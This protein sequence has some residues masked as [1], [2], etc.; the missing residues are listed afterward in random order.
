MTIDEK[1]HEI[2]G[3]LNKVRKAG[4]GHSARCPAHNDKN[5]SLCL[6]I[7][8][9]HTRILLKCH[10]GCDTEAVMQQIG[11][12]LSYLFRDQ[13]E[14][15]KPIPSKRV[16]EYTYRSSEGT[17][18][19]RKIRYKPKSFSWEYLDGSE[20]KTGKGDFPEVP[21]RLGSF[22]D[23]PMVIIAE[24]EKDVDRLIKEGFPATCSSGSAGYWPNEIIKYFRDKTVTITYDNDKA[25]E[26]HKELVARK[27]FGIAKEIFIVPDLGVD[28]KG[29]VSDYFEL[30]NTADDFADLIQRAEAWSANG[31]PAEPITD[32]FPGILVTKTGNEWLRESKSRPMPRMLFGEFW[33]EGELCIL[34]A[35]TGLGKSTLAV[36]IAEY[37][38]RGRP[39]HPLK[40]EAVSQN[41]L[42]LD[43]EL[44]DKQFESR[45]SKDNGG[46]QFA[47]N[48]YEFSER[49]YRSEINIDYAVPK[50]FE[51][52]EEYLFYS[53]EEAL[54]Q[55]GAAVLIVDNITYL[56]DETEQAKDALPLMKALKELKSK[57]GISIL[58]LA[59]TP[60]RDS[61]QPIS[62]N[63]LAGSKMLMNFT[64]SSFA[65]GESHEDESIRYLKQIKE[66]N[67][68]KRYGENNVLVYEVTKQTNF[69]AFEFRE[70]GKEMTHLR[71]P[72][73][74]NID[75]R[76]EKVRELAAAG[77]SQREIAEILGVS[78]G[79]VNRDLK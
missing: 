69:L 75:V 9:D 31:G 35:D 22:I 36:Q 79:T 23:E 47:T 73:T 3:S 71:R 46:G 33:Y 41:V 7:S 27:L 51:S 62:R 58:A 70:F 28:E 1:Y 64:D 65:I 44:S 10:A 24:G 59:H 67:T 21:Y 74:A 39:F 18:I 12:P 77:H 60:K 61:L 17:P 56:R 4:G 8:D 14:L 76:R 66:R 26:A 54:D 38:A 25:G 6:C 34:F 53:I 15:T 55:S 13:T 40:Q 63:H 72:D 49:F 57:R 78:V 45:Y 37:L 48:H 30:G 68:A 42:Y 52:L 29:D 19:R 43:F 11:L 16:D 5:P 20:W 32:E 2:L 50:H